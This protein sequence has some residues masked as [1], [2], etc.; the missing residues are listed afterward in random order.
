MPTGYTQPLS[1]RDVSLADFALRCARAFGA[2]VEL[3]EEPLDAN[4]PPLFEVPSFY[5]ERLTGAQVRVAELANMTLEDAGKACGVEF[6]KEMRHRGEQV[7]KILA[8]ATRH[9]KLVEEVNAWEPPTDDHKG[10]K[11]FM[12][13]QLKLVKD[14]ADP[15]YYQTPLFAKDA[16]RWLDDQRKQAFEELEYRQKAIK[17]Q[18]DLVA[19]RNAWITALRNSLVPTTKET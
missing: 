9:A 1:E 4:L 8:F 6:I 12:M 10:L 7:R 14:E 5:Y 15:S 11:T 16:K 17:E 2:T 3:R 13:E 18:E 19:S